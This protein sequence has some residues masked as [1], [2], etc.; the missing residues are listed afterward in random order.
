MS[1]NQSSSLKSGVSSIA[2]GLEATSANLL[3][4]IPS[5]GSLGIDTT[6]TSLLKS[7]PLSASILQSTEFLS[8]NKILQLFTAAARD[9]A[10]IQAFKMLTV[11]MVAWMTFSFAH[12]SYLFLK[13]KATVQV[14]IECC[15]F[16]HEPMSHWLA[17]HVTDPGSRLVIRKKGNACKMVDSFIFAPRRGQNISF[18]YQG[19][20]LW[21]EVLEN[22]TSNHQ[23]SVVDES[24]YSPSTYRLTVLGRSRQLLSNF[25]SECI[26]DYEDSN[27]T[28]SL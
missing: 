12:Q 8:S 4:S 7:I 14:D 28:S 19:R 13:A 25:F 15:S 3:K 26:K 11:P 5:S 10:I 16:L 22:N 24:T 21:L 23:N 27:R 9:E 17:N 20:C 2:G 6:S 1:S 18:S